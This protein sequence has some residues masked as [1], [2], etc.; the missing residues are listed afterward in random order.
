MDLKQSWNAV[1]QLELLLRHIAELSHS[2][3]IGF[4]LTLVKLFFRNDL[5]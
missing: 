4:A 3:V 2:N 1:F 5:I